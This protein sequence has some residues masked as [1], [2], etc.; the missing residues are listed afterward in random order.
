MTSFWMLRIS[1]HLAQ[2]ATLLNFPIPRRF[3]CSDPHLWA[4]NEWMWVYIGLKKWENANLQIRDPRVSPPNHKWC[5]SVGRN[6]GLSTMWRVKL[7]SSCVVRV[8]AWVDQPW[9]ATFGD[10]FASR[11]KVTSQ[12]EMCG[13]W[14][15]Q[16]HRANLRKKRIYFGFTLILYQIDSVTKCQV[17]DHRS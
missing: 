5:Q 11:Q 6:W 1:L 7:L 9:W 3:V 4:V 13:E 8:S 12:T 15:P 17:R 16:S 2:F 10:V 14:M